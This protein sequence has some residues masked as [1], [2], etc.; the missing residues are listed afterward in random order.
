MTYIDELFFPFHLNYLIEKQYSNNMSKI[1]TKSQTLVCTNKS[2]SESLRVA[3]T[4]TKPLETDIKLLN[5]QNKSIKNP[6]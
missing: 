3:I 1:M 4:N 6:N 5:K 2:Y